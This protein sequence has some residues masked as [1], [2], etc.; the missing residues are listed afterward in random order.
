VTTHEDLRYDVSDQIAEISLAPTGESVE[1]FV[2]R[3]CGGPRPTSPRRVSLTPPH[4]PQSPLPTTRL[5]SRM[6]FR[7]GDDLTHRETSAAYSRSHI[8]RD[9]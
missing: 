5:P 6:K 3:R 7:N 8:R 2:S 1:P 4:G 9:R